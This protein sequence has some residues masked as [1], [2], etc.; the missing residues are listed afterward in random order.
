MLTTAIEKPRPETA[1]KNPAKKDKPS[2][3]DDGTS[4]GAGT[5]AAANAGAAN[6]SAGAAK[7]GYQGSGK[8]SND[9]VFE[10]KR[11]QFEKA[12]REIETETTKLRNRMASLTLLHVFSLQFGS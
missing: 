3:G 7:P 12:M 4:T 10:A 8:K 6:A 11:S 5:G 2:R 9:P 1:S